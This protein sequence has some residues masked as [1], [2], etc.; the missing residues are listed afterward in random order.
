MHLAEKRM[1][2]SERILKKI[3][4]PKWLLEKYPEGD[5]EWDFGPYPDFAKLTKPC[6]ESGIMKTVTVGQ[7]TLRLIRLREL[8]DLYVEYLEKDP[9]LF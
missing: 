2:F 9:D 1:R 7:S 8:I 5:W 4:P 3:T 6:L